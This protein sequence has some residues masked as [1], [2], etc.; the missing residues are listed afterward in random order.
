MR[1]VMTI[2]ALLTAG[3]AHGQGNSEWRLALETSQFDQAPM[4]IVAEAYTQLSVTGMA[5]FSVQTDISAIQG[6]TLLV[7]S[8]ERNAL[9]KGLVKAGVLQAS[10]MADPE[11]YV[12]QSVAHQGHR[13]IAVQG[14]SLIG[15][16]YGLY[17]AL[18]RIRVHQGVPEI[19]TTRSP[20]MKMRKGA[21]WGRR[22]FGGNSKEEMRRALRYSI[23]W[24]AGPAILD[25][26]PWN[27]APEA[28][29]NE[30][31]R[32]HARDLIDY[33]HSLG[34]KY[35]AFANEFTYH[36]SL[37][38]DMGAT[39]H[40]EDPK[41][42]DALQEK[43]RMLLTA[44]PELDAIELCN[45]DISGFWDEYRPYDVLHEN[46]ESDWSYEKRFN[47]F[48][49]KVHEVVA[50]EFD[51]TYFHFTW[52]L[53]SHEQHYQ[54]AVYRKIFKDN[55]PT[56]NLY[57]I[58]K[59]TSADR[60]WHQ[61]YNPTFNQSPHKTI[62]CFETMNYYEG[63]KTH[64]FPTYAGPY[65]QGGIQTFLQP[66]KTN[67]TGMSS[68]AGAPMEHWGTSGAYAYVLWR[69][70]WNPYEDMEVITRDFA[71]IHF[72]PEAAEGMAEIF[73][74]SPKAY[75]YGL[76]IE[77][78]SYGQYNSF[79]HM[80]VGNFPL[81]GYPRID[82]GRE[83]LEFLEKLYLRCKP[84]QEETFDDLEH[85]L[86]VADAM[87]EKFAQTKPLLQNKKTA[88][89]V[90]ERV[91]MTRCL[92]AT[93]NSYVKTFMAYFDYMK[94]PT[95]T[96]RQALEQAY[97]GLQQA[98]A[99]FINA[100]KFGYILFGVD[101]VLENAKSALDDVGAAQ[102]ALEKAPSRSQ[103]N[104]TIA[105]QQKKYVEA[106]EKHGDEAVKF[107]Y[108]EAHIDGRDILK[109]KGDTY[110]IDHIRWD[111]PEIREC[112]IDVPLPKKNVTVVIK[113]IYSRPLHPFVLE[114]PNADN[115]YT[116]RVYFD[117][118]PGSK[119]WVKCE[120]YFLPEPP[121]AYGLELPW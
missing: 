44:L 58:P 36:P 25:L 4:Q 66:E 50:D 30:K 118:L 11:G 69:L 8:P 15:D 84:W 115:D 91:Y 97:T 26:V 100:P 29:H 5:P 55:I 54:A 88:Q 13:V 86:D 109:L 12:I 22:G 43:F 32:A 34:M 67:L 95:E 78:V 93:N 79:I 24:V 57:L 73:L 61:P 114:Q 120:L 48:V 6:N 64:I 68:M 28:A 89:E 16:V 31:K 105:D 35:F 90:E 87:V 47:T 41:F 119:D 107:A 70:A 60:W 21:A 108:F 63:G 17:W 113:D 3:L 111:G 1:A 76:H 99:I 59:I 45:D 53:T 49:K 117:D 38:K 37:I 106:L 14:G 40:P 94:K 42:W 80:R 23:N 56:N 85:G 39:L 112:R 62:V 83:H 52:G 96:H 27:S 2:L 71:S 72:G 92:I 7:G 20:F 103:L 65:Y 51:K 46:P 33:A 82:G 116:L 19:N 77:P 104:A 101:Q 18:D 74:L 10:D 102:A 121:E 98:R 9:T 81:E 75:K 110:E